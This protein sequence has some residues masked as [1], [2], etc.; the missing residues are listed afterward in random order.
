MVWHVGWGKDRGQGGFGQ[1]RS[2]KDLLGLAGVSQERLDG[3]ARRRAGLAGALFGE[4]RRPIGRR[5]PTRG[6]EQFADPAEPP[7]VGRV[8]L[9][10]PGRVTITSFGHDTSPWGSAARHL[11]TF[12]EQYRGPRPL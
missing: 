11:R 6:R 9:C 1:G 7:G 4:K 2:V 10:W 8:R 3:R 12:A 5:K